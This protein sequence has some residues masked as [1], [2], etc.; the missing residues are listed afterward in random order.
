MEAKRKRNA[1]RELSQQ[2][3]KAHAK[4]TE[5]IFSDISEI[6]A[7]KTEIRKVYLN[8]PPH[9]TFSKGLC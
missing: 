6:P 3:E 5:Y 4:N 7:T 2:K 1:K 9:I 8:Y